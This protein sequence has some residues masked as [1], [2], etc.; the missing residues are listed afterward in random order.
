[1]TTGIALAVYVPLLLA[2]AIAVWRRPLVAVYAWIVGVAVH[3]A[4]GAALYGAGVRGHALTAIQAW[5]EILL[6]IALARVATSAV[7]ARAL[8]FAPGVVDGL[9]LAYGVLVCVYA[10]IPQH[11]LGGHADRHAVGLALKHNLIPVAAYFVGRSLVVSREQIARLAWTVVGTAGVVAALGLIDVYAISI[12]SWRNSAVVPYFHKQLGYDYHGTGGLPENFIYNV[13]GDKPFL[14]RLVSTF[15]SPL[16]SAYMLVIALL[17]A[18][19]LRRHARVLAVVVAVAAGGLLFTFSRSSLIALA[20]GLVVLGAVRGRWWPIAAALV[21]IAVAITWVHV[22]PSIA[23]TGRFTA[24]DIRYQHQEAR[25]HPGASF[26]AASENEPSIRSHLTSLRDGARTVV[27][28]PQG[29]GLGNAGQT[30]SRTETPIKAGESNYTEMGAEMGILGSLLWIAW[31]AALLVA[32]V[33][34]ARR[35]AWWAPAGVASA[36]VA[37]AVLA[38]QTDVIGDPWVG[39]VLW[40]L[41]GLTLSRPNDEPAVEVAAGRPV[42]RV[43]AVV[44]G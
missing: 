5:K 43:G 19:A 29:Y 33:R 31:I 15:L 30:A 32:L 24:A 28:H 16:A 12:S 20:A 44:E 13:G 35:T 42:R 21:T 10:L 1:M 34:A 37:A 17:L 14:R 25:Q 26:N 18:A 23:A 2:G 3:N 6:A 36:A 39:Y 7:R 41:A 38:V 4:V 9:A 22:F 27:H 8:A 40:S 11:V